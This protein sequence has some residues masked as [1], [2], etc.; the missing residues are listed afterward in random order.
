MDLENFMFALFWAIIGG[1]IVRLFYERQRRTSAAHESV[2]EELRIHVHD[3]HHVW[4]SCDYKDKESKR[5]LFADILSSWRT[6]YLHKRK[7][8]RLLLSQPGC[9]DQAALQNKLYH[10][11]TVLLTLQETQSLFDDL[12][13]LYQDSLDDEQQLFL[14]MI[15]NPRKY[16]NKIT[17]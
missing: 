3:L 17:T 11:E 2:I 10:L 9:V 15:E 5:E 8:V 14:E 13:L 6:I 12:S 16:I 4:P 7:E 1:L